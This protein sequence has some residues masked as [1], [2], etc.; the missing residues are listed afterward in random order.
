MAQ[1]VYLALL[2]PVQL[3]RYWEQGQQGSLFAL[4]EHFSRN[5]VGSAVVAPRV[6]GTPLKDSKAR[7]W[8]IR[9]VNR[10]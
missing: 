1:A 6:A 7:R 5:L 9:K 2:P 8:Q 10:L 3:V 4:P